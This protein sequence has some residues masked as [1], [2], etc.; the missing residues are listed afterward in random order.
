M[1][2]FNEIQEVMYRWTM[3]AI[4]NIKILP[5]KLASAEKLY[6]YAY[7]Y[8][9][10]D[11]FEIPNLILN[12]RKCDLSIALLLFYQAEGTRFWEYDFSDEDG[13][14]AKEHY[15][16]I[17]KL[18]DDI[19]NGRYIKGNIQFKIPL[20]RV[21]KYKLGKLLNEKEEVFL[22]DIDGKDLDIDL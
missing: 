13:F 9:W 19:V 14:V 7:N 18:H 1:K 20:S 4:R 12:N 15:A 10:D 2:D 16:F 8:N 21:E 22:N 17:S 6:V 3:E 11:G 5:L